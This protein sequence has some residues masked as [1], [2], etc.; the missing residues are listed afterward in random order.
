MTSKIPWLTMDLMSNST[1]LYILA[2]VLFLVGLGLGLTLSK[3]SFFNRDANLTQNKQEDSLSKLLTSRT[4]TIRGKVLKAEGKLLTVQNSSGMSGDV[5]LSEKAV[6]SKLNSNG[7]L[8][9]PSADFSSIAPTQEVLINLIYMDGNY[10]VSS[11]QF[12][13]ALPPAPKLPVSTSS[14]KQSPTR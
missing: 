10:K 3:V 4:A 6:V 1:K 9:S 2:V 11:I 13:P 8:A 7:R 14:S 5:L 12:L